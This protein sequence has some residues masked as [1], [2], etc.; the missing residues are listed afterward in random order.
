MQLTE[1]PLKGCFR[2]QPSVFEDA[3]GRFVKPLVAA[4]LQA[5]SLRTD[6]VEQYHST[7]ALGVIRGL[8][9]QTPPHEHAKLVY[10]AAGAVTDVLL[11]LRRQSPTYGQAISLPLTAE[12]GL[13]LYIAAGVAHGFVATAEPAL[14]IYNVTSEY[15]PDHDAGVRWDSFGFNWGVPT[16][17]MS[18]RDCGFPTLADF[19]SPF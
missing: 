8:H 1:L 7:S 9:F 11:D 14:M 5:H 4:Q 10:C 17:V 16:P 2:L 19:V 15:A 6:F 18:E 3:R 12:S 13:A